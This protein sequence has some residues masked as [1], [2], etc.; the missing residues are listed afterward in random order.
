MWRVQLSCDILTSLAR[1][2]DVF[3]L[4]GHQCSCDGKG[5]LGKDT[6]ISVSYVKRGSGTFLRFMRF[7]FLESSQYVH[8]AIR[9]QPQRGLCCTHVEQDQHL[10]WMPHVMAQNVG[11]VWVVQGAST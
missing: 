5:M 10:V 3:I 11:L 7:A 1:S 6:M 2:Q 9:L 4:I 8:L